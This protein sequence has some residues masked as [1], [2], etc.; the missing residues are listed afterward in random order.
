M[1]YGMKQQN[2]QHTEALNELNEHCLFLTPAKK[3]VR[4]YT[5]QNIGLSVRAEN[6][7]FG[8]NGNFYVEYLTPAKAQSKAWKAVKQGVQYFCHLM[9]GGYLFLFESTAYVK[10]IEGVLDP[11]RL[12]LKIAAL[13]RAIEQMNG[14]KAVGWA[15]PQRWMLENVPCVAAINIHRSNEVA[16]LEVFLVNGDNGLFDYTDVCLR[17]KLM[18]KELQ[19]VGATFPKPEPVKKPPQPAVVQPSLMDLLG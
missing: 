12:T 17:S 18:D 3:G 10:A 4:D 8:R 7:W 19:S 13:P 11:E 1:Q 16:A 5:C 9:K 2:D 15:I 6:Y 14:T